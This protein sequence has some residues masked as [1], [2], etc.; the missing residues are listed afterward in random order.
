MNPSFNSIFHHALFVVGVIAMFLTFSGCSSNKP[1]T[2]VVGKISA[3]DFN[4]R[5]E[6]GLNINDLSSI[7]QKQNQNKNNSSKKGS[8]T[9][10]SDLN[11]LGSKLGLK[12]TKN[13]N[14]KLYSEV[15]SWIGTPYRY[16]GTSKSGV[17]CSGFTGNIYKTVYNIT[18]TRQSSGILTND[19]RK[20]SKANLQEGDLVFF[21]TDGRVTSTPNHVGIYLK[22][23][24]FAHASTSKG[25]IVSDLSSDY[26]RKTFLTGGR[27]SKAFLTSGNYGQAN[28]NVT[29]KSID[30]AAEGEIMNISFNEDGNVEECEEDITFVP[31]D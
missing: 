19:C 17:D 29:R 9:S 3:E 6:N 23:G 16:G 26:Y 8:S 24:K 1:T 15:C 14:A 22:D 27:V 11:K 25:V 12:L 18:L 28:S 13:N 2:K 21:R 10:S 20:V 30:K 31:K 4:K 5:H 7:T